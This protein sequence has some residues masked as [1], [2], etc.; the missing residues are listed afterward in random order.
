MNRNITI[1][2]GRVNRNITIGEGGRVKRNFRIGEG[3]IRN[4]NIGEGGVE[5]EKL[6]KMGKGVCV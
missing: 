3:V 4:F 2:K 6:L 5:L 1:E